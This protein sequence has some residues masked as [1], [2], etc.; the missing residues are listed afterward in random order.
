VFFD[1]GNSMSGRFRRGP[2]KIKESPTRTGKSDIREVPLSSWDILKRNMERG[3]FISLHQHYL[4]NPGW[5]IWLTIPLIIVASLLAIF[6]G[7]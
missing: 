1:Q 4:E 5:M 7:R 6:F 2:R 3:R